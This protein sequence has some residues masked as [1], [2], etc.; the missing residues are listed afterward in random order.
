LLRTA[1]DPGAAIYTEPAEE[2]PDVTARVCEARS[3][4]AGWQVIVDIAIAGVGARHEACAYRDRFGGIAE[5]FVDDGLLSTAWQLLSRFADDRA[6]VSGTNP[7]T[8][9]PGTVTSVLVA[10][11]D[12]VD[13]GQTLVVIEAMKMEHRIRALVEGQVLKVRVSVGDS[14]DAHAVV[15]DMVDSTEQP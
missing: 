1:E 14:V 13:A 9:V 12:R 2:L 15:V 4:D 11:G 7:V 10:S 8:P 5:V 3:S 6:G